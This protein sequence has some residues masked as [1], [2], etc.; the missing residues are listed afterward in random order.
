MMKRRLMRIWKRRRN[1]RMKRKKLKNKIVKRKLRIHH[2]HHLR[3]SSLLKLSVLN[4]KPLLP[5][6]IESNRKKS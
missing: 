5:N 4:R 3:V 1:L 6:L 2:V